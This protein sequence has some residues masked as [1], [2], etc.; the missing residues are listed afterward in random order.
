M[1]S[2]IRSNVAGFC[3]SFQI[4]SRVSEPWSYERYFFVIYKAAVYNMCIFTD[5]D[6]ILVSP[7]F[8]QL[9]KTKSVLMFQ[10]QIPR[11]LD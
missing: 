5:A 10:E 1:H 3:L 6:Q 7:Y 8:Q 4:F 2:I 11:I 9:L